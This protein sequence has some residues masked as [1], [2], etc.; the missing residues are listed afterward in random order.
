MIVFNKEILQGLNGMI[1]AK[2]HNCPISIVGAKN[3]S[4]KKI[5]QKIKLL[6]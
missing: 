6:K 5:K 4:S 2:D 1:P 3:E